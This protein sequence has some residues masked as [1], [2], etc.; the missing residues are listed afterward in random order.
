MQAHQLRL[1]PLKCRFARSEATFLG[2]KFDEAGSK[3]DPTRYDRVRNMK[4]PRNP[5]ECRMLLGFYQYFRAYI[6]N[7]SIRSEPIAKLT[8]K[9][10]AFEWTDEQQKSF[11]YL[12]NT[13]LSEVTLHYPDLNKP[14][15]LAVDSSHYACGFVLSQIDEKTNKRKVIAFGGRSFKPHE[16][17]RK[18]SACH[19]E[20]TG[21]I[22]AF[23]ANSHYFANG[24]HV[25]LE[26]DHSSLQFLANLKWN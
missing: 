4:V 24:A 11:D 14:Y 20:L 19:A 7:Y 16:R 25:T 15:F 23:Q 3:I 10:V 26:T 5:R 22:F 8:R 17:A 13:L 12:R 21:I 1:N 18:M 6:K 9:D 2:F